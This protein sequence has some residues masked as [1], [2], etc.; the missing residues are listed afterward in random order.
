LHLPVLRVVDDG[1]GLRRV[2]RV[3]DAA[4]DRPLVFGETIEKTLDRVAR[5]WIAP[6][7]LGVRF[8]LVT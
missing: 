3:V 4:L 8:E 7:E 5:E 1:R 2:D 6:R